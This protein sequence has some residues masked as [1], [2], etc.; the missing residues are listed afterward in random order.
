MSENPKRDRLSKQ[1]AARPT[2]PPAWQPDLNPNH[3]AGPNIGRQSDARIEAEWTAF[4]LRKRGMDL[5]CVND[6]DLMQ[7]PVLSHR[8][9]LQQGG[10]YVDLTHQP[11]E[12]F[13]APADMRAG[14]D[15]HYVPKDRVP[16]EI[17]NRLIGEPKPGQDRPDS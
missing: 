12:E 5:G 1:R 2:R 11:L 17:W 8:E 3:T 7:V 14:S 16:D 10:T 13:T 9:R 4:H 15:N 6:E